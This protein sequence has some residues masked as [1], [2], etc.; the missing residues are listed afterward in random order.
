MNID[1]LT[2]IRVYER[3]IRDAYVDHVGDF[4]D[5]VAEAFKTARDKMLT[6]LVENLTGVKAT[7]QRGSNR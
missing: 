4:P 2:L 5:E 6:E 7:L 3:F 1:M